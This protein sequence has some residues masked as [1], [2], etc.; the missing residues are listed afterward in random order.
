MFQ[1]PYIKSKVFNV[2]YIISL[3]LMWFRKFF[4]IRN[5][6]SPTVLWSESLLVV[7]VHW[8]ESTL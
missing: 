8:L 3:I 4:L 2:K 5:V 1:L 7:K 6:N